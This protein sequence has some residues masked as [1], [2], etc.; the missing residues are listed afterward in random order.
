M[1]EG[2]RNSK[3]GD[4]YLR[5][6]KLKR[7]K[8]IDDEKKNYPFKILCRVME[9]SISGYYAWRKRLRMEPKPRRRN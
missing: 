8:F 2:G 5:Q 4:T 1:G 6:R 7:D 3:K 9:V